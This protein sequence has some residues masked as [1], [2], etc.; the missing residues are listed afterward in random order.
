MYINCL[1][2]ILLVIV[3]DKQTALD[4]IPEV[5]EFDWTTVQTRSD[6]IR[7][8]LLLKYGGVWADASTLPLKPLTGNIEELNNG[9]DIFM[10]KQYKSD[11]YLTANWFIIAY[12]K[13]HY[14]LKK[15]DKTFID[16][17][18]ELR[19]KNKKI[20]YFLW[21]IV[22]SELYNT[23]KK[24]KDIIDRLTLTNELNKPI[25]HNKHIPLDIK[26]YSNLPLMYKRNT[27]IT[28]TLYNNYLNTIIDTI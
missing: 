23:D 25:E 28:K 11:K 13:N 2:I 9:T 5:K 8:K 12:V 10:Y 21:Y 15:V 19:R 1:M 16:K 17:L 14:L 6:I 7:T 26:Y 24:I 4:L 20:P 18:R 27:I 3:L 22:I